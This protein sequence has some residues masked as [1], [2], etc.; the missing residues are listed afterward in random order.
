MYTWFVLHVS[1]AFPHWV[2]E[3]SEEGHWSWANNTELVTLTNLQGN[4]TSAQV[5]AMIRST[6]FH[7]SEP[8]AVLSIWQALR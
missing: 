2:L 7:L 8:I 3:D 5:A 1:V 4:P 6:W